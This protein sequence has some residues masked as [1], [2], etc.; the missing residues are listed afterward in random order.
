M[1]CHILPLLQSKSKRKNFQLHLTKGKCAKTK[2][3][4]G[5]LE[6]R[7]PV[8]TIKLQSSFPWQPMNFRHTIVLCTF[9]TQLYKASH[10]FS[11]TMP[12]VSTYIPY[13]KM[14]QDKNSCWISLSH[15]IIPQA[16]IGYLCFYCDSSPSVWIKK[17]TNSQVSEGIYFKCENEQ[18]W[19]IG[20]NSEITTEGTSRCTWLRKQNGFGSDKTP[21][22]EY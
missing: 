19:K 4:L 5:P 15:P 8:F 9:P 16:M 13:R 18:V 3:L 21:G 22:Y 10:T 7:K 12:K 20:N 17:G 2:S 6:N 14:C 11:L 1:C